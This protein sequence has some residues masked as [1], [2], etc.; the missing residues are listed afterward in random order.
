MA[1]NIT[2]P[3]AGAI[4][5][6]DDIGGIHYPRTKIS[7]GAD[8]SASDVS[9]ANPMPVSVIGTVP[10]SGTF[11]Q[12]TQPV[13]GNV[14]ISG[15]VAVT[16]TFWPTT[17]PVSGTVA[18][19]GALTNAELRATPVP[20]SGTITGPLTDTQLRATAVAVSGPL[21][22]AQLRATALP[23]SG[24]VTVTG[25]AT[26]AKQDELLAV[27]QNQSAATTWFAI[28]PADTA[29][30]TVPDAIYVGGAGTIV[31][32]GSNAVD[33][34]FTVTAGQILPI[35]PTQ[36]RAASTATGIIGLVN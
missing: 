21:T 23:V 15:S 4:L 29:L 1:D 34:T 19:T 7:I 36:V 24:A 20:I 16:G 22:D 5:A 8:G 27:M 11:W 25:V 12:A 14:G 6:T 32:R 18:V 2:A 30:A 10:V 35:R 28:T 17:Q 13:S 33:A 26:A 31:A 9:S 3:A